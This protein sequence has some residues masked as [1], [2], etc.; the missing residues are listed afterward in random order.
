MNGALARSRTAVERGMVHEFGHALGLDHSQVNE[1]TASD[2]A[3]GGA[4][5]PSMMS[6]L[7]TAAEDAFVE[8]T[9]DDIA[10]IRFLYPTSRTQ[11]QAG[12]IIGRVVR[13]GRPVL[14]ANVVVSRVGS[15]GDPHAAASRMRVSCVSDYLREQEGTFRVAVE[16]GVYRL[17]VEPIREDFTAG[18]SVGPYSDTSAS[19]SF[20]NP[21]KPL[22]DPR[23]ITVSAG[24]VIDVGV[25]AVR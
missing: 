15:R 10:W 25:L 24:G 1:A 20:I 14:G 23:R 22:N 16:P 3:G 9:P 5:H 13:D 12:I 4:R 6:P 2:G 7:P 21:V 17:R 11:E 8:L 18:S 19:L